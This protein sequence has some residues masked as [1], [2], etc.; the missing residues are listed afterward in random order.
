[1]H[2]RENPHARARLTVAMIVRNERDVLADSLL[3]AA[4]FAD[5]IVVVDT[6]STDGTQVIAGRFGARLFQ[7][8]WDD[9]FSAARN[10]ALGTATGDWVL[11]LD[12]GETVPVDE[13]ARLREFVNREADAACV[14]LVMVEIPPADATGASQ[15]VGRIRLCPRNADIYFQGR[16]RESVKASVARLG[17]TVDL[18]PCRILRGPREHNDEV[19]RRRAMRDIRL[20]ELEMAEH[21]REPRLLVTLGEIQISAGAADSAAELFREAISS[22]APGSTEMLEAYYGLLTTF[23]CQKAGRDEQL[24]ICLEA[25]ERFPFDAQ[26]LCAMGGY[27]QAQGRADLACRSYEAALQFGQADPE[28]WHL[29]DIN[30]VVAACLSINLQLDDKSEAARK[31]LEEALERNP[32]SQRLRRQL[33]NLHVKHRR[34]QDALREIGRLPDDTPHREALRSAA[35]GACQAVAQNWIPA[36]SYLQTAYKA[37]CRDPLCLRW[38]VVCLMATGG[39]AAALPVLH[40]WSELDPRNPEVAQYLEALSR[41]GQFVATDDVV[42]SQ[43]IGADAPSLP[44][45]KAP[46]ASAPQPTPAPTTQPEGDLRQ[47]RRA[48]AE[49]PADAQAHLRLGQ[50]YLNG[51]DEQAAEAVWHDYLARRGDDPTV[52]QA[53]CELWLRA[54][55]IVDAITLAR[56]SCA[57]PTAR[58]PFQSLIA[59]V[60][61]ATAKN[62]PS[63]LAKFEASREAGYNHSLV[64]YYTATC[65]LRLER[66]A[67][68]EPLARALLKRDPA[69]PAGAA[70]LQEIATAMSCQ[71]VSPIAIPETRP[72]HAPVPTSAVHAPKHLSHPSVHIR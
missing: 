62:W 56:K 36:L 20:I 13:A 26:L 52:A 42:A 16:V 8:P 35:R 30:Q 57:E 31:V 1:M 61:E 37:G 25:M 68:A 65:L 27:L 67:E 14:Y 23:D 43:P 39:N 4:R 29:R 10:F 3:S 66:H 19:K 34:L 40:E 21:G 28:S 5:E 60:E 11:W 48:A 32:D 63:A 47:L 22:A 58:N 72:P 71:E 7:R 17:L 69:F 55:R 70:L 44:L 64:L 53:L 9:D 50:F 46:A 41:A 6:G 49:N 33:I 24:K 45:G 54:G 2:T 51:S 15:Q 38:L 59:G 12:A 18:A